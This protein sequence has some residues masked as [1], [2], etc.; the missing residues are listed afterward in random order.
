VT[1]TPGAFPILKSYLDWLFA[2][3]KFDTTDTLIYRDDK[4][5]VTAMLN[6]SVA[7]TELI[8]LFWRDPVVHSQIA[9][10][11]GAAIQQ[12]L[13]QEVDEIQKLLQ[14][15]A[16]AADEIDR[17]TN[18]DAVIQRLDEYLMVLDFIV[19]DTESNNAMHQD[20]KIDGR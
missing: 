5:H 20:R 6:G 7:K 9:K 10:A 8:V 4:C 11:Q 12:A 19:G 18:L 16:N 3:A 14:G 17:S 15:A 2:S 13:R 1:T